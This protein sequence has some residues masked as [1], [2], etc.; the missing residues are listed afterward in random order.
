M[1]I[2]SIFSYNLHTMKVHFDPLVRDL[3]HYLVQWVQIFPS[4]KTPQVLNLS[5]IS[6]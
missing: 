4:I 3:Q 1:L 5:T 2:D 6:N